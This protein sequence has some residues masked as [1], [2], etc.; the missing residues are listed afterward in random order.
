MNLMT[1]T[2]DEMDQLWNEAK[3]EIIYYFYVKTIID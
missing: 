3:E 2:L 1:M